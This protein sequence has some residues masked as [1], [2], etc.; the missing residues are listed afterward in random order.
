[1]KGMNGKLLT[2]CAAS[3]LFYGCEKEEDALVSSRSGNQVMSEECDMITFEGQS[4][5]RTSVESDGGRTINVAGI[6]RDENDNP[7]DQNRAMIF[8]SENWTG[9]DDDLATT[10]W[11]NML[12][13]QQLGDESAPNDNQWGSELRLGFLEPV[14][15][16]SMRVMDI[17]ANE[18]D[19]WAFVYVEGED[20]P[21][22]IYLEPHGDNVGFTVDFGNIQNVL[23]LVIWFDGDG[24]YGS[25]A[26]DN[27]VFCVP[28]MMPDPEPECDMISFEGQT[29]YRTTVESDGGRTINVAGI[30][31]D[32]NDNPVDQNRA[33]IFDSENWTGDD[34]DLAT[35]DW[36]NVLISQQLGDES[37]PNDNQWGSELRLGFLE[38][39]TLRSMRVMDIDANEH[40]SWAFVYVEGEDEPRR[41]YLEPHG[42]NVGFTV[43]FGNIQNVLKL[44]IW[45]DGDGAYGSGA[46][47]NVVFCV[48]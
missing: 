39:V 5:Y 30:S 33:M 43:D 22:R 32:E 21:R 24:A 8:D 44:V 27:V 47:D 45:F 36:G 37:A 14:T 34:D 3:L 9:D 23:K 31:R 41:I 18:H 13:V 7:V 10:D 11:G 40:D 16:R 28:V 19:S 6:A 26:I 1:M 17:D 12:I 29:G 4:G 15:L 42:D 20:E 2:L 48:P 46:I 38:P 25:G 35:T